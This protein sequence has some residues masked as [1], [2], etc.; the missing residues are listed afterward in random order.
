MVVNKRLFNAKETANY[1]S[2][3]RALLYQLAS[4]GDIPNVNINTRRLLNVNDLDD[5]Y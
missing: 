4:K 1:L 5:F 2:I 3:N